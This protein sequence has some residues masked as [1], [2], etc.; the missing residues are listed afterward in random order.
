MKVRFLGSGDAFGSGGR[1][2]T[3]VHVEA[4]AG[5][6][7][8]DCGASSLI[9]MRRFGVDPQGVDAV[10]LTHLHGDHFAGVPFLILDAQFKR[11]T[12]PL[13]VAG[14]P[15]VEARVRDAMEVLFPGSSRVE[16]R[17]ATRFV[18]WTERV[19]LDLGAC[20]V[21]PYEVVH[22]SGAP[23]FALRIACD[24]RILGYSGDTEWTGALADAARGADLF[25][26]EALFFDRPIRYHLD[27]TTLMA[28]RA[29]LECRRLVLTHMGEDVLERLAGLGVEG[30]Q[31]GLTVEL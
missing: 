11:R 15:G 26:A 12:R 7:L 1:F 3:C 20:V 4:A 9:A 31:D 22:A 21:T 16:R 10:L 6:F 27:F 28:H 2:Q 23:P 5:R 17:F 29:E 24:G 30:A 13:T 19:S 18:E 25:V 14:P 8:V